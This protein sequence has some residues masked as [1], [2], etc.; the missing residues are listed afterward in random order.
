[1]PSPDDHTDATPRTGRRTLGRGP[2]AVPSGEGQ[3]GPVVEPVSRLLEW[4]RERE[5]EQDPGGQDRGQDQDHG[6]D[7]ERE[8]VRESEPVQEPEPEAEF[9]REPEFVREP[10]PERPGPC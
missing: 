1:M 7:Q 2:G 10:E 3:R 9:L 4:D 6:Q 8:P 5:Q